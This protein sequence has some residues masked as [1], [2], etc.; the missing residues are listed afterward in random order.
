[1][2]A[3]SRANRS[4]RSS[5]PSRRGKPPTPSGIY[6]NERSDS[7]MANRPSCQKAC[8]GTVAR[9]LGLPRPAF[10]IRQSLRLLASLISSSLSSNGD[11]L[12]SLARSGWFMLCSCWI[13]LDRVN[14]VPLDETHD[15][16]AEQRQQ[17]VGNGVGDGERDGGH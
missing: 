2:W 10:S 7:R 9:K 4:K 16:R 11:R 14:G 5:I 6:E 3:H 17:H 12:E 8:R 1:V 13:L 15:Q